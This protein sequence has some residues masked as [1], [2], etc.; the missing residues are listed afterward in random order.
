MRS[1]D[2]ATLDELL[3]STFSDHSGGGAEPLG[4][5]DGSTRDDSSTPSPS[6]AAAP[7]VCGGCGE[8]VSDRFVLLAA[9]QAWHGACLRC[10]SCH[11]ELQSHSSLYCRDGNI[12]CQQDYCSL[13]GVGRC[14]RCSQPIPSSALVMRSGDMTFHLHCFSCQECDVT[15]LPG[16]LYC[17]E[18]RSLYCQSHYQPDGTTLSLH[19]SSQG[20]A[21]EPVSSPEPRLEERARGG[22]ACR[23]VKRMRTCF[24]REQLRALE[25]YFSQ[26]H[27]PDGKDWINLSNHTG[28]PKRVLQVWFQNARAKLRRSLSSDTAVSTFSSGDETMATVSMASSQDAPPHQTSTIDQ[29]ELSLLTAPISEASP[30]HAVNLS[31]PTEPYKDLAFLDYTTQ[32]SHLLS[33][34]GDIDLEAGFIMQ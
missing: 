27:N 17:V 20:E 30:H 12:Y 29:L 13:F 34:L 32:N 11:C 3:Y 10:S 16:N 19:S 28:L 21:E 31:S 23:R 2:D 26:K 33:A 25:A 8:R 4:Q 15:L 9:G 6:V 7:P 14:A 5:S 1:A 18:G 22:G 24:R